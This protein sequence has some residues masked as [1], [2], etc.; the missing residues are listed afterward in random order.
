MPD[1]P[2]AHFKQIAI[3]FDCV[4]Q[5]F[6]HEAKRKFSVMNVS[7]SHCLPDMSLMDRIGMSLQAWRGLFDKVWNTQKN[8]LCCSSIDTINNKV[9]FNQGWNSK[10]CSHY[11]YIYSHTATDIYILKPKVQC[12]KSNRILPYSPTDKVLHE[13]VDSVGFK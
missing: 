4:C 13:P 7:F 10:Q 5:L 9:F 3:P 12:P 11:K 1:S 2:S 6:W 8:P